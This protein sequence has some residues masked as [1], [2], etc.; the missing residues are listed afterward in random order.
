M[1]S[2]Q[3]LAQLS[4][5]ELREVISNAQKYL[6]E[7]EEQHRKE[8]WGNVR[9]AIQKYCAELKEDIE[10]RSCE[11]EGVICLDQLDDI[12]VLYIDS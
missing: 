10:T 7:R 1:V 9:T 2:K 3:Q 12:G 11:E 8:L 5:S 6:E 4:A